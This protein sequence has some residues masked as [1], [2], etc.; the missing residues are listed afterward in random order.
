[1]RWG[2]NHK[3]PAAIRTRRNI[4]PCRAPRSPFSVSA[5]FTCWLVQ[6]RPGFASPS[7]DIAIQGSEKVHARVFGSEDTSRM[8]YNFGAVSV[9][10]DCRPPDQSGR[11][12]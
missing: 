10:E 12:A 6:S 7:R 3:W 2:R 5:A 9:P 4:K 8:N 1:M 11:S